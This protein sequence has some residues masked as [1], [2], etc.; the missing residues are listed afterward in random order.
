MVNIKRLCPHVCVT[1]KKDYGGREEGMHWIVNDDYIRV[2]LEGAKETFYLTSG[3]SAVFELSIGACITFEFSLTDLKLK[4]WTS[5]PQLYC[6]FPMRMHFQYIARWLFGLL[7]MHFL[8][9]STW[10]ISML[11]VPWWGPGDVWSSSLGEKMHCDSSP[12][13]AH[14]PWDGISKQI[15]EP[16]DVR[17]ISRAVP[18]RKWKR[19]RDEDC[20][21]NYHLLNKRGIVIAVGEPSYLDSQLSHDWK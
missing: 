16:G 5:K 15:A 10:I 11:Q 18:S 1:R 8:K 14:P 20:Q 9:S 7:R 12:K 19:T 3:S 13:V 6:S 4:T 21:S 17:N 2:E